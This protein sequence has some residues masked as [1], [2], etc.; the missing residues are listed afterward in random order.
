MSNETISVTQVARIGAWTTAILV[1]YVAHLSVFARGLGFD[2]VV[3]ALAFGPIAVGGI[4]LLCGLTD[5]VKRWQ[6]SM[7]TKA[8]IWLVFA[9]SI[10]AALWI[11][12]ENWQLTLLELAALSPAAIVCAV[13]YI[14]FLAGKKWTLTSTGYKTTHTSTIN[15]DDLIPGTLNDPSSQNMLESKSQTVSGVTPK[16]IGFQWILVRRRGTTLWGADTS[17]R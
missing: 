2:A 16:L 8:S 1:V 5:A 13:A 9:V 4:F 7:A 6:A 17:E 10:A 14:W 11:L 3:F 12:L 15:S